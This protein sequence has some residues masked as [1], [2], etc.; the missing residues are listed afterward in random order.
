MFHKVFSC[1]KMEFVCVVL[2]ESQ[3]WE[4]MAQ[5][6]SVQNNDHART[7]E[8]AYS[9]EF[10]KLT[11]MCDHLTQKRYQSVSKYFSSSRHI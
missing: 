7:S 11:Q 6:V 5:T 4:G 1:G 9:K 2:L 3:S 10:S 8:Y